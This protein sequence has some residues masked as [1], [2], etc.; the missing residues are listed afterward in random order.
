MADKA[1]QVGQA[2]GNAM[3][4]RGGPIDLPT[5]PASNGGVDGRLKAK[6]G[7]D[8]VV[9][10]V[11]EVAAHADREDDP[12][13]GIRLALKLLASEDA[14]SFRYAQ[15]RSATHNLSALM[16]A[17]AITMSLRI[18]ATTATF[19]GFLKRPGFPGGSYL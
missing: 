4:P 19:G 8:S 17:F 11:S 5:R 16:R 18:K 10:V 13:P 15:E 3:F 2:L 1:G 6:S 12:E 9:Y 7:V 14:I